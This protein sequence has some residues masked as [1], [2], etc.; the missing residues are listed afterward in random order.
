MEYP[1]SSVKKCC[2]DDILDD[3]TIEDNI[4]PG[5]FEELLS[6]L[7]AISNQ[8]RLEIILFIEKNPKSV[9]EISR[10]INSNYDNTKKHIDRLMKIG[11]IKK[12]AGIG[13]ETSK[14]SL[15][16]WK[17]SVN[18]G[19]MESVIRSLNSFSNL[20]L[21]I[22]SEKTTE[23]L[24]LCNEKFG[25]R[26][27]S[28]AFV[29]ALGGEDDGK[30]FYLSQDETRVGRIAGDLDYSSFPNVIALSG[31]YISVTRINSSHG[32]FS[33]D[34]S[35]WHFIDMGSTNGSYVNHKAVEPKKRLLL[36]DGDII[37]LGKGITRARLV[38][39]KGNGE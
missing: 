25:S 10:H 20:N 26:Y 39:H 35:G 6:Y 4:E 28:R 16:V 30:I 7:Q 38:F 19:G 21:Q 11:L 17:Y 5:L 9:K 31:A 29:V 34:K 12:E 37:D 32:V 24:S 23:C 14:G 18:P 13:E 22:V 8:V 33:L 2:S 1:E 27:E 3:I 36:S 15:P